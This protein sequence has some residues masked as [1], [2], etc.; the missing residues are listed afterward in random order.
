MLK[1]ISKYVFL[2]INTRIHTFTHVHP[3]R[4]YLY[5]YNDV[6]GDTRHLSG[7]YM[8]SDVNNVFELQA[9][10]SITVDALIDFVIP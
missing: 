7:D 9:D 4:Y 10:G 3:G 5:A 6:N 2:P 8:S 1:Y